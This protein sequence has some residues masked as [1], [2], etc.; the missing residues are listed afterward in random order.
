[1]RDGNAAGKV[2]DVWMTL[3]KRMIKRTHTIKWWGTINM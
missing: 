2:E 1:V 3:W